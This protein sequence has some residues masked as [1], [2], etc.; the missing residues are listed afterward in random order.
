MKI[1]IDVDKLLQ[2]GQITKEEYARLKTLAVEETGSLAF[3]I[4]IG[5]GVIATAGGA[6]ALLPHGATAVVLGFALAIAG[7]LLSATCAKEWGL[8]GSMLLL[9]GS[10]AAAG[11][12]LNLTEGG[13]V[14]FLAVTVLCLTAAAL[15]RSG[16][17]AAISVL[18]LS[19]TVGAMTAYGHATYILAIRQPT[20]TVCLFSLLSLASYHLSK[21]LPP[22]YRRL[23]IVFARTS[24][25]VVNLGFWV[26]SLWGDSLWHQRHAWSFR[27]GEVIPDWV[28]VIGWAVGLIATGVWAARSNK[29]WVVNLLAVFGAIHFYTQYFERLGATPA[30]VLIAGLLAL[31]IAFAIVR[32]NKAAKAA[33][34]ALPNKAPPPTG[35]GLPS[36]QQLTPGDGG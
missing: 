24:L 3:N 27:S 35:L 5:F 32:Y 23:A 30:S 1:V 16:L 15:A 12:I 34:G 28:F 4:L 11:G 31:G 14:G 22:D 18:S 29:R 13:F 26:G 17:L 2:E 7:L 8:L 20:V 25:F 9:V 6:L 33:A 36:S 10:L 19:A 21:I